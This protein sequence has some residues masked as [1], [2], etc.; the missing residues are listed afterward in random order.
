MQWPR[1]HAHEQIAAFHQF[2]KRARTP[3]TF[4]EVTARDWEIPDF[5]VLLRKQR[6]RHA[7]LTIARAKPCNKLAQVIVVQAFAY[8]GG[9]RRYQ[10]PFRVRQNFS[11]ERRRLSDEPEVGT[12]A[13]VKIVRTRKFSEHSVW[14]KALGETDEIFRLE[15]VAPGIETDIERLA[16]EQPLQTPQA[17]D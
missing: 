8:V 17:N 11:G 1:V 7:R 6:Q 14:I 16:L 4:A 9:K 13:I 3:P 12:C 2:E 10:Y 5:S 15:S